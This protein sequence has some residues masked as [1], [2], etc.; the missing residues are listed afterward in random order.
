MSSLWESLLV[1]ESDM[2]S[3]WESLLVCESD[4]VVNWS[5]Y[6]G[7]AEQSTEC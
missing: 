7:T 5:L 4:I 2:C 3:K 1:C 6:W